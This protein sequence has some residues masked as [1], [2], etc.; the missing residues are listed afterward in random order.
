MGEREQQLG[1]DS[2][3]G[4]QGL[5]NLEKRA[6]PKE[7]GP[8]PWE[9]PGFVFLF[10]T[11]RQQYCSRSWPSQSALC[12]EGLSSG[13]PGPWSTLLGR[14]VPGV[15][16]TGP[17]R[18][19]SRCLASPRLNSRHPRISPRHPAGPSPLPGPAWASSPGLASSEGLFA[20]LWTEAGPCGLGGSH[21][22]TH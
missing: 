4:D 21:V 6:L 11:L 19:C 14:K 13:A 17:P 18:L 5:W 16:G 10:V 22:C 8:E 12:S 15:P 3:S 20:R 9:C 1:Q 2:R 7:K